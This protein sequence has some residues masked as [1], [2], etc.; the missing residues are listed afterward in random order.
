MLSDAQIAALE[1]KHEDEVACGE[2][3]AAD[4]IFA[5]LRSMQSSSASNACGLYIA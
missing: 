2:M 4:R 3:G 5:A 1:R